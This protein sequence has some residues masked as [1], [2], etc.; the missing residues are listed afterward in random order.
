MEHKI[1]KED[2]FHDKAFSSTLKLLVRVNSY[3]EAPTSVF[4]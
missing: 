2:F 1:S 4:D 3:L